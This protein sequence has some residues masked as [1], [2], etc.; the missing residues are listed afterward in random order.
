MFSKK[1]ILLF[2]G[3]ALNLFWLGAQQFSAYIG[4]QFQN[5]KSSSFNQFGSSYN[6]RFAKDLKS[7]GL[8]PRLGNGMLVGISFGTLSG[9]VDNKIASFALEYSRASQVQR[10][11]FI[12]GAVRNFKLKN[13]YTAFNFGLNFGI[14]L[15]EA[16]AF[17]HYLYIKT[18]V[19]L[20][21][22]SS[23][24]LASFN[25]GSSGKT[26]LDISG[27][28]KT[29]SGNAMAGISVCYLSHY[30][31]IKLYTRYN[32]QMFA[33]P[34]LNKAKPTGEDRLYTDVSNYNSGIIGPEV[35]NNFKYMQY[36]IC[37]LFGFNEED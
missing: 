13:N 25:K 9:N 28:Y 35:R 21:L 8:N 3:M 36:G 19:G 14:P 4:P 5:L 18:E 27:T 34:L 17:T 31:G 11:E 2:I 12:D 6:N 24:I 15:H 20:G 33:G 30:V 7:G 29:F 32:T 1:K 10:A 37:L 22:G 16:E 23:K 26:D